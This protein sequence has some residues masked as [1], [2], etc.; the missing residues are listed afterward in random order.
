[1]IFAAVCDEESGFSGVRHMLENLHPDWKKHLRFAIV[2]EPTDLQPVAAHKG[3][4]RWNVIAHG[5]AAHSSTPE[6][7]SNAI[8]TMATAI[9][10][11]S[12]YANELRSRAG[13]AKLGG[14]SLSVG[15]IHGGSAVN[16]VPEHCVVHVDRRL[17]PG[18]SPEGALE[19]LRARLQHLA[20]VEVTVPTV[21]APAFEVG[22][23]S[24]AVRACVEAASSAGR[25]AQ[26]QYA[27]YCTD[28]SFYVE[29]GIEAVVFGPGS[30]AQA[31]TADEWIS[32]DE[33]RVGA[34]AYA[35]LLT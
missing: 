4:V 32:V 3:V 23:L 28:A 34:A 10:R 30:I 14:P 17:V 25:Q 26:P 6:L 8:Y 5:K 24:D 20:D 9:S 31:H 13:H 1:V 19:E 12:D 27:N 7:G 18:E 33:L 16:V 15:T 11:M 22:D 21:A 35:E 2:A 29:H